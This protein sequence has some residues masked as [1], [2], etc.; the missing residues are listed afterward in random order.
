[1]SVRPATHA[2]TWYTSNPTK[3]SKQIKSLSDKSSI[4]PI[5]GARILI[6]PHAGYAYAG[7]RLAEA[8]KVWDTTGVKRIFILGPSHHVYFKNSVLLS[9]YDNYGTPLG[10]L[11][12]DKK[13]GEELKKTGLFK[14]MS[15]TVDEGEHSFEMHAPFIKYVLQESGITGVTIIPLLIS[16]LDTTT[17]KKLSDV[18]LPYLNNPE[19]HF[20][21]STDFCHW[22]LH[23]NFTKYL[24]N[25]VDADVSEE[26]LINLRFNGLAKLE[27]PI[28]KSIQN[29]DKIAMEIASDG[30]YLEW[31]HYMATTGN[32]ICGQRPI[33][34]VLLLLESY[35]ESVDGFKW[36]GYSQSSQ[37]E[38][39]SDSSVS[40]ASGYVL[41]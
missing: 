6:G 17:S 40:Y 39:I 15:S 3:L 23:F 36:L 22:G 14:Y 10:N 41:I 12:V 9:K 1:M 34:I 19:N 29:L 18:L 28:W 24:K 26:D 32:T 4:Q 16:D 13:V 27:I 8:F 35:S 25:G 2:G 11:P 33:S 5:K 7:E 20:I 31:K 21:V 38:D 30:T 37:V